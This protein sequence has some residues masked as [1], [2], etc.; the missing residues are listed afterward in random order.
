M[1]EAIES[2]IASDLPFSILPSRPDS[3]SERMNRLREVMTTEGVSIGEQYRR[4]MEAYQIELEYGRT[5]ASYKGK[6]DDGREANF[7][8]LAGYRWL[9]GPWMA[10]RPDTGCR[11][12]GMGSR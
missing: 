12:E 1:F 9:T 4:L 3:R 2:F 5:M 11:A 7:L 10:K 8:R 6:L